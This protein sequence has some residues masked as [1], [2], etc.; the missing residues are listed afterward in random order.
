ME[1]KN[2]KALPN[3]TSIVEINYKNVNTFILPESVIKW[4]TFSVMKQLEVK[5]NKLFFH[6]SSP[7]NMKRFNAT[8]DHLR[9]GERVVSTGL[10]GIGKSTEFNAYLMEFLSHIGGSMASLYKKIGEVH[11]VCWHIAC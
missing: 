6:R 10:A 4:P 3:P 2:Q 5:N 11:I 7:P 8:V 1:I 9:S